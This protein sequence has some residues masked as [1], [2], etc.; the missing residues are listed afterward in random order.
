MVIKRQSRLVLALRVKPDHWAAGEHV[1]QLPS[2][3]RS[4]DAEEPAVKRIAWRVR[5]PNRIIRRRR[6]VLQKLPGF[7]LEEFELLPC[8]IYGQALAIG[9][10]IRPAARAGGAS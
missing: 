1:P 6:E 3:P 7:Q 10:Q 8:P 4:R 2:V 5:W 9:R